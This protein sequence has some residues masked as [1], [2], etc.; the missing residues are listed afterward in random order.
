M[1]KRLPAIESDADDSDDNEI[2]ARPNFSFGPSTKNQEE[3]QKNQFIIDSK[4]TVKPKQLKYIQ[5]NGF[6]IYETLAQVGQNSSNILQVSAAKQGAT[7]KC[8]EEVC[9]GE[10]SR[11]QCVVRINNTVYGSAPIE[12]TKKEAKVQAFD[13]ALKYARKIHYTIKVRQNW[14]CDFF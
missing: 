6:I 11:L 4:I 7:V 9:S 10:P 2:Q 1:I 8:D 14:R 5:K 3:E 12:Q 13:N